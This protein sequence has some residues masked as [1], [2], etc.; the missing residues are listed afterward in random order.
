MDNHWK[1]FEIMIGDILIKEY[2]HLPYGLKNGK[3]GAFLYLSLL[4]E[5]YGL[6]S[7]RQKSQSILLDL[8]KNHRKIGFGLLDGAYGFLYSVRRLQKMEIIAEDN[9]LSHITSIIQDNYHA[10]YA[11]VPY[12]ID[13]EDDMFSEGVMALMDIDT[14]NEQEYYQAL[15]LNLLLLKSAERILTPAYG[16][17]LIIK[18]GLSRRLLHSLCYF[19]LSTHKLKIFPNKTDFLISLL[20]KHINHHDKY[21]EHN[22]NG[23]SDIDRYIL[24]HILGLA[25]EISSN[26]S[27][28]LLSEVSTAGFYSFIYQDKS[29]FES[30]MEH[31]L[32][33]NQSQI[34]LLRSLIS[35][36]PN[37]LVGIGL[38]ILQQNHFHSLH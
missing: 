8:V 15:E 1:Q 30:Y 24:T 13:M 16:A 26:D 9:M 22:N 32:T 25:C 12:K 36:S 17:D 7:V 14:D 23:E 31:L 6:D 11:N 5:F 21:P 10:L 35:L 34:V 33:P 29:I 28:A 3:V 2:C 18:H 27:T 19:I 4:S 37:E 20:S 38:G